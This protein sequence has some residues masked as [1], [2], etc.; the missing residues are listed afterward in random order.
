MYSVA[1]KWKESPVIVSFDNKPLSIGDIPFPAISICPLAK[2][3]ARKFN[4]TDVYR[5]MY[6]LEGNQSRNVTEH[7]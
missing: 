1:S 2:T 5:A 4:Y 3:S 7:E 6:K